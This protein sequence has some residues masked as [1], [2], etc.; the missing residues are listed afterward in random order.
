MSTRH[1]PH[2]GYKLKEAETV[3]FGNVE[4]SRSGEI[5][6]K[7]RSVRLRQRQH[8]IVEALIEARGRPLT[9]GHLAT[10]LDLDINDSTITKYVQRA[11]MEF[12]EI[13]PDFDQIVSLR[14]FGAYQWK[15]RQAAISAPAPA[16]AS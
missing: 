5:R 15:H 13:D 9:R 16:R 10:I 2:C 14:G 3:S 4:I 6:F 7:R 11:R 1:C 12:R 8:A